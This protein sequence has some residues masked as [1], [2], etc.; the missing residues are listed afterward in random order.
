MTTDKRIE[1]ATRSEVLRLLS[2]DEAGLVATAET[3][4]LPEGDEYL[5]LEHLERGVQIS[6]G[7]TTSS[8]HVLPRSAVRMATWSKI[9]TV[10]ATPAG[11]PRR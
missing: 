6:E 8:R 5:D 11:A 10:L 9:L 7:P 2:D 4:Q 1:Y 3:K